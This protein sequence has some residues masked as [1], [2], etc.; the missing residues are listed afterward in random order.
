MS[1]PF[2]DYK[3]FCKD[4]NYQ[5][6]LEEVLSSGFLIGGPF[7]EQFE[8]KIE[9]YTQIKHCVSTANAT[10]ALE[11]IFSY[12][13]L[14]RGSKVLVP[15]HTMQATASAAW[16][17]GLLP[18]PIEVDLD[19]HLI[20]FEYLKKIPLNDVSA[21]MI[22]Q[23]NGLVCDMDPIIEFCEKNSLKLV[24]D[25]AQGIGTF[26][27][28]KHSGSFGVGGCLSFY[29]AKVL[30]CLGDGGALI[31]NDSSLAEYALSVRDH[32]RGDDLKAVRWGRNSRLDSLNAK[33]LLSRFEMLETYIE[34]RRNIAKIYDAML[35]PLEQR[36]L[37]KLPKNKVNNNASLS[38]YQNYEIQINERDAV[39]KFLA[40][41]Q[42]S[43]IIQWGGYSIAHLNELGYSLENLP[44]TAELFRKILLLPMNHMVQSE[45]IE[46]VVSHIFKYFGF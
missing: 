12:L 18:V 5:N 42:I 38:T 28:N 34:K 33:V 31:T 35:S 17:N 43:T 11:I 30:G 26:Y 4:L 15:S 7:V 41:N 16:T 19:T 46:V 24:E 27:K 21:L 36:G 13:D 25:S 39:R 45:D 29:P 1:V 40:N 14:P 23:L 6:N 32:G 44:K 20:D 8:R 2:F 37:L 9:E 10:D 22:T 3:K